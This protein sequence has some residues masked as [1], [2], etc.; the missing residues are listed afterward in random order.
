VFLLGGLCFVAYHRG[1][2]LFMGEGV[3]VCLAMIFIGRRI[4]KKQRQQL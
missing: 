2:L 4:A 1:S 3:F